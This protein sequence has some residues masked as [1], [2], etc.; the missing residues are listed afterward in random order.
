MI[1]Q[2]LDQFLEIF[3]DLKLKIIYKFNKKIKEYLIIRLVKK[4]KKIEL[5]LANK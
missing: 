5:W 1:L 3:L 4:E 2:T